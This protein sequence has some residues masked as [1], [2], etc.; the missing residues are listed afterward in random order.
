MH[1]D[2]RV[3]LNT[4]ESFS[5]VLSAYKCKRFSRFSDGVHKCCSYKAALAQEL[6]KSGGDNFPARET[7]KEI[8]II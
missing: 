8:Y 7:V 5:T 6:S 3:I 2:L 1:D 4:R